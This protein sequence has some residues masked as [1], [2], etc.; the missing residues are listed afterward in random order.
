MNVYTVTTITAPFA[1][2][3][4]LSEA[5]EQLRLTALFTADDAYIA[6]LISVARDQA[7]KYCNRLTTKALNRPFLLVNTR[8]IQSS[9]HCFLI[10]H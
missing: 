1:E 2:P 3:I 9:R 10:C 7:E 4:T 6:S 5:K 8:L